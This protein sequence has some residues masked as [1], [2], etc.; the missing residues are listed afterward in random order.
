M[1]VDTVARAEPGHSRVRRARPRRPR[2]AL[3]YLLLAP[4]LVVMALILGY[5]LVKLVLVSFQQYGLRQL[6]TGQARWIGL[7]NY[8][9]VLTDPF[10]WTV[11]A[12]TVVFTAVNVVATMILSL[13][14]AR[15]ML[16]L[17]RR[18][19]TIL[20]S[21]LVFVWATPGIVAIAVW[22]WMVDYDFGVLN[23]V[24]GLG[25]HNWFED[26]VQGLGVVSALV[27]WGALPFAVITLHAALVQVPRELTEAAL[28]DGATNRQVFLHVTFPIIRPIF[29][30]VTILE[31]I[32][33]FQ[34]FN[35][36]WV[37]NG[38]SPSEDYYTLGIYSYLQSFGASSYGTGAAIA[39][40]MVLLLLVAGFGYT[41]RM[42]RSGE[43]S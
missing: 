5:P 35:Q 26:P 9:R 16:H 30:L 40:I 34:I 33:D 2:R 32:W 23:H 25:H 14:I 8:T 20:T 38:A 13:L 43:V 12:R 19:K 6:L 4:A 22:Q 41:R 29:A 11:T 7:D 1:Q 37:L 42:V 28:I 24:L 15:L 18:A 21:S 27:V 3:P 36:I 31:I 17:G 39:V 10:F